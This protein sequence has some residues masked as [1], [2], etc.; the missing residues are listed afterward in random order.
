MPGR[1]ITY[2]FIDESGDLGTR[3][4]PHFVIVALETSA[5]TPIARVIRRAR[6]KFLKGKAPEIKG[7]N[8]SSRI[9]K[10]VLS[11]IA[12][13]DCAIH[14]SVI[15]K[16]PVLE[17]IRSNTMR[18]FDYLCGILLDLIYLSTDRVL[19]LVDRRHSIPLQKEFNEYIKGKIKARCPEVEVD[20]R[21]LDSQSSDE[22]KAVDFIAWSVHRHFDYGESEYYSLVSDKVRNR[23][24]ELWKD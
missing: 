7:S 19:I 13:C 10:Y 14:V 20:I 8:S 11:S 22:L 23:G 3:G 9:R 17:R 6:K 18:T 1:K 15:P 24:Q 5:P 2:L 4:S 21:H 12:R 16:G